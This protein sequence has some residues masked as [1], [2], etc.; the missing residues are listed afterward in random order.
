MRVGAPNPR[1]AFDKLVTRLKK[2]PSKMTHYDRY[3]A[4]HIAKAYI[5]AQL[6][7]KHTMALY[8]ANL[9]NVKD[10]DAEQVEERRLA[11]QQAIDAMSLV[12]REH[13][14]IL[15]K[16]NVLLKAVEDFRDP[17][18]IGGRSEAR[19]KWRQ[20]KTRYAQNLL[21]LEQR[22]VVEHLL[23]EGL[24]DDLDAAP[25]ISQLNTKL[26]KIMLAPLLDQFQEWLHPSKARALRIRR[27]SRSE[28][29]SREESKAGG[30]VR[31]SVELATAAAASI[32]DVVLQARGALATPTSVA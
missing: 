12:E 16:M 21:L 26:E 17:R 9:A 18:T 11:R 7:V 1:S 5:T 30:T 3:V 10:A 6:D 8:K 23:H 31:V 29:E 28:P 20:Y 24:L 27:L 14:E 15:D 22:K 19:D 32:A 25:L 13:L 4:Y 2:A